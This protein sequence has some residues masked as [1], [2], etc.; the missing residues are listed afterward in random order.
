M[1][2]SRNAMSLLLSHK[3]HEQI[4]R[5]KEDDYSFMMDVLLH[6]PSLLL[7]WKIQASSFLLFES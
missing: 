1:E 4:F 5:W 6:N 3:F 7:V 2:S